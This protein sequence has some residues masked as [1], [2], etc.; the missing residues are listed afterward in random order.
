MSAG[1]VTDEIYLEHDTRDHIEGKDRLIAIQTILEKFK[2]KER[3]IP[4]SPRPA[5]ID[6]IATIH[7]REYISR[8]KAEIDSGGG[9][10]DPD[11]YVSS[12]SF[13]AALYAAGGV[14]NSV[15]AVMDK[16]VGSV[17]ALVRPPGHH[18]TF[19]HQMG[20]CLFNNVAIAAKFALGNY[21][22]K[23]I[24]IADF[25][26]HH[27]NGTQDAFYSDRHV[28]YFSTHEYPLFPLTGRAGETGTDDGEG[29]NINVPLE[30]NMGDTE[31]ITVFQ[32]IFLPAA[33][34][35]QPDLVLVSAG[36]DAHWR[37]PIANMNV[38]TTGFA[39]IVKTIKSVADACCPGK[40]V[41][42]LEGGYHRAALA[43]SVMGTFEIML[44]NNEI[45]DAMGTPPR[46]YSPKDFANFVKMIRDIHKL[47]D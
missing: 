37:D 43:Y 3:L 2:V 45:S 23:R 47:K 35:F 27:G 4:I 7:D 30:A 32:E 46:S 19:T 21:D 42:A 40:L 9:W 31:Y 15:K 14:I 26:V 22:I 18:A 13:D 24:L 38:T 17:F 6:E 29:Y 11:T 8:L 28:L 33:Q 39:R 5:T 10:L 41:F 16:E 34:R 44:G 25:D 36:Y 12:R 20:F 1:Y